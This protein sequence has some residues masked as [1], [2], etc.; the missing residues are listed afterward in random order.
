[1]NLQDMIFSMLVVSGGEPARPRHC[2]CRSCGFH[3][4]LIE[5]DNGLGDDWTCISMMGRKSGLLRLEILFEARSAAVSQ[6]F[7]SCLL[8]RSTRVLVCI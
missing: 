2:S 3:G 5:T 1:M 4:R 8:S 7:G 6:L